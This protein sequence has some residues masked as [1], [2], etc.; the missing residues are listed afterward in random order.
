VA[1]KLGITAVSSTLHGLVKDVESRAMAVEKA[2]YYKERD[3]A[4]AALSATRT[5]L[6]QYVAALER[7]AGVKQT[8][9]LRF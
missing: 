8:V 5:T 9:K 1:K 6:Y 3:E 4:Y 7:Q 2:T